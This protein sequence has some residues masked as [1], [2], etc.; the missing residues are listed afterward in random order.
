MNLCLS[1]EKF[2]MLSDQ[3]IVL[4]HHISNKGI[5]VDT[6]KVKII[7]ELPSP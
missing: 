6:A 2:I 4:G 1:N 7:L 3:S 5:Q